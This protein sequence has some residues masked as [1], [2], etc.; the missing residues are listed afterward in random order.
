MGNNILIVNDTNRNWS[1]ETVS[2]LATEGFNVVTCGDC[3]EALLKVSE[4]KSD[5]IIIDKPS[6]ADSFETCSELRQVLDVPIIILGKATGATAW[7][8]A[9][10]SGADLYLAK[11]IRH[12]VLVARLR[13]MLRRVEWDLG[14]KSK[15]EKIGGMSNDKI[16]RS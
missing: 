14:E 6:P 15:V 4:L 13:A 2:N 8:K 12:S 11:P 3:H 16:E 7:P 10:K 5:L 1:K 9:V